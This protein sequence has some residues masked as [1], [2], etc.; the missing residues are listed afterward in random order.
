ME[1]L[2]AELLRLF[3]MDAAA[4]PALARQLQGQP[5]GQDG[6]DA[7]LL[8]AGGLTRA[9]AI[10][11]EKSKDTPAGEHWA[12]LCEAAN[13]LQAEHGFPA[14]A[15]SVTGLGYCL[16]IALAAPVPAAQARQFV[17]RVRQAWLPEGAARAEAKTPPLPPCLDAASGRWAA[18]IH[19]GMGASFADEPWLE[20]APPPLAQAA[21]LEGVDSVAPEEF[22]AA[23]AALGRPEAAPALA[24]PATVAVQ[25]P[26][27]AA[28]APAGLLLADATLEDIVRHLHARNIEPT[29]RHLLPAPDGR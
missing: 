1:K 12:Q 2:I 5:P 10:P 14:P 3:V 18:F 27:P 22:A 8:A 26:A 29:F 17:R 24:Q 25:A 4:A 19:P 11:F 13:A 28:A 9:V 23:F 21:F 15:V 6:G 16:W 20:I 7:D